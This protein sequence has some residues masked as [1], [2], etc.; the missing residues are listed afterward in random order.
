DSA[1]L[2]A[3]VYRRLHKPLR[4]V[5]QSNK[6][7]ALGALPIDPNNRAA[8]LDRAVEALQ[9][10]FPV[11]IFPEGNSNHNPELRVGK[12]GVARLTLRTGLPV[13]PIGIS[14]TRGATAWRALI[15][16]FSL[17]APCHVEIGSPLVFPKTDVNDD[18]TQLLRT[19]TD[20]IL[21]R[22]SELSGK[23]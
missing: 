2:A 19:T 15:W 3:A 16:F 4:I 8:V 20:D 7:R 5:S 9:N 10:G 6:Y 1:V 13:L 14:G 18:E 22:I 11:I 21:R 17:I 23:P 12:T